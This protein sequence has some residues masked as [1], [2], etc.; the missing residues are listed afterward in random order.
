MLMVYHWHNLGFCM[1]FF[2]DGHDVT[3]DGC[4]QSSFSSKQNAVPA[5]ITKYG[6]AVDYQGLVN[7]F[8]CI[9]YNLLFFPSSGE[10]FKLI[11]FRVYFVSRLLNKM[12]NIE[13][14]VTCNT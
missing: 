5:I 8:V 2:N 10:S 3:V 14:I 12:V 13:K 11:V 9:Y 4:S 1:Q 6:T 7:C